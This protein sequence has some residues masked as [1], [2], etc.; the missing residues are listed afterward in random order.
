MKLKLFALAIAV[1]LPFAAQAQDAGLSYTYAEADYVNLDNDL[2]GW[3]L[4]GSAEL[5]DTGL[6]A[7]GSYSWLNAD[8][9]LLGD[10]SATANELGIGYH[11]SVAANTD[12]IGE[13]AYRNTE[14]DNFRIDG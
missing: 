8:D 4:R 3:G 13:L 6:Y 14:F 11:H 10:D 7:L 5:G 12:L 1:A 9:S 2:D